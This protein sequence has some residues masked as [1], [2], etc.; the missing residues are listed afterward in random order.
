[1]AN[2]RVGGPS[3][4]VI[5]LVTFASLILGAGPAA[6]ESAST[7]KPPPIFDTRLAREGVTVNVSV[8]KPRAEEN[9]QAPAGNGR[10]AAPVVYVDPLEYSLESACAQ[11]GA[12][13]VGPVVSCD[14]ALRACQFR[15]DGSYGSLLNVLAR[16]KGSDD[17]WKFYG[18]TCRADS[19]PG[20]PAPPPVPTFGQIQTAFRNLPFGKP[21]V[22]IQPEGNV[23]LVNLPTYYQIRWPANGL[24]AG[25]TSAPV[26][27]LSWSV[28]FRI[29][30]YSYVYHYGDGSSSAPTV[31]LG[32]PYPSGKIRHTYAKAGTAPVRVDARLTGEFRVNGGAWA[33]I[34]TVADL[35]GE[36]VTTLTVRS[37]TN[38]LVTR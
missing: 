19:V 1:M 8:N 30:A 20:K 23:T 28:Q 31:D 34:D 6:A 10:G 13:H 32:G 33:P 22:H 18:T 25:D 14:Y 27:L 15:G 37:A 35:Q 38:R 26:Q 9:N 2:P 4:R 36:P 11:R 3:W 17:A 24:A 29:S 7:P 21:S 5:L 16:A 12:D